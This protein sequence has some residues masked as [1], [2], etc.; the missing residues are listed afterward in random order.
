MPDVAHALAS[1]Q[2]RKSALG[3]L[4]WTKARDLDH[5]IRTIA[6][7]LGH[8]LVIGV[9]DVEV[10][11]FAIGCENETRGFSTAVCH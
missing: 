2:G 6:V 3:K 8:G 11:G 9:L 5:V 10:G 1:R 7:N 4:H